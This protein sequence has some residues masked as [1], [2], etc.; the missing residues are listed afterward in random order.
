MLHISRHHRGKYQ[1]SRDRK[2]SATRIHVPETQET[3]LHSHECHGQ[4]SR[5]STQTTD[6][7]ES[8]A[9]SDKQSLPQYPE[10]DDNTT[11]SAVRNISEERCY[12]I[13][14]WLTP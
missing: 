3:F 2:E 14:N 10:D 4:E 5:Q 8:T 7:E 13:R 1:R 6:I 9:V 12:N 11:A